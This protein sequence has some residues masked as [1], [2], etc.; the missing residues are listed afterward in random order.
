MFADVPASNLFC[1]YIEELSRRG[2]TSGCAPGLFC[3]SDVVTRAQMS[4]FL[5]RTSDNVLGNIPPGTTV[6]AQIDP[7]LGFTTITNTDANT[8]NTANITAPVDGTLVI[9]G[10]T[11]INNN[12]AEGGDCQLDVLIDGALTTAF[13]VSVVDV[14][15][16]ANLGDLGDQV[17]P[18][19]TIA[20]AVSAGS[21]TVEQQVTCS[22]Q[23]YNINANELVLQFSP[24]G[25]VTVVAPARPSGAGDGRDRY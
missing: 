17:T 6:S 14:L 5:V 16:D 22:V 23:P 4:A 15:P 20:R 21:H 7:G 24:G 8:I 10:K 2:I 25:S 1:P 19:Y 18:A 11:F 13:P 9:S 12:N 3:P